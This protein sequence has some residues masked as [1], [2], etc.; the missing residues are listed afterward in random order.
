MNYTHINGYKFIPLED[1]AGL[2]V[3]LKQSCAKKDLFGTILL[4]EE[5]INLNLVGAH[6]QVSA[7]LAE[8]QTD[9]HFADIVFK[10]SEAQ[11]LPFKRLLVKIKKEIITLG[12]TPDP[13]VNAQY[14][15]TPNT[16]KAWLDA[17]QKVWLVDTRNQYETA[18][19][20]FKDAKYFPIKTFKE[21]PEKIGELQ[22]LKGENAPIVLYC[23]GGIR[24]EKI[25]PLM[26][27]KG[28][29][30]V[31]QLEGGILNYFAECGAAHFQGECF[32]FD[33]RV[34]L[35]STLAEVRI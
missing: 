25:L 15:L 30:N 6:A 34:A 28:F 22:E 4:S 18:M 12:T 9:P 7:F 31:W 8:L 29:T 33:E 14:T 1:L 23:T 17:G 35:T 26:L 24:C 5:G 2:K 16:L 20:T 13:A 19:G 32:V 21:F 10:L 11:T 3:R 27:A